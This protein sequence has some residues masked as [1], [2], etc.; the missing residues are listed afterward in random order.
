MYHESNLT[1]LTANVSEIDVTTI[2]QDDSSAVLSGWWILP[3][4]GLG[5][6]GWIGLFRLIF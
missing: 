4:V 5:A 3:L 6:L 1:I 2:P